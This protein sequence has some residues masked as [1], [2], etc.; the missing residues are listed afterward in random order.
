M[1]L[2]RSVSEVLREQVRLEVECIDRLRTDF[3]LTDTKNPGAELSLSK[4]IRHAQGALDPW[5]D[6]AKLAARKS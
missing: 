6:W 3:A 5:C 4:S 1:I 2:P